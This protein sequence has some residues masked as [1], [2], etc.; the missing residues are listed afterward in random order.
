[1]THIRSV[2]AAL[3]LLA[4]LAVFSTAG[5]G[6]GG[7]GGS[8]AISAIPTAVSTVGAS[9]GSAQ[10]TFKIVVPSALASAMARVHRQYVSPATQGLEIRAYV[11]NN[12]SQGQL[13]AQVAIALTPSSSNCTGSGTSLSCTATIGVPPGDTI[14]VF[15]T[16]G[17]PPTSG[18]FGSATP[19]GA[20]VIAQQII[21][22]QANNVTVDLGG[23]VVSIQASLSVTQVHFV[24]PATS[25]LTL[26]FYDANNNPIVSGP[27]VD[28]NGN[29]I[30]L[31]LSATEDANNSVTVSSG[32]LTP[33]PAEP[34]KYSGLAATNF[35]STITATLSN[36]PTAT[37]ALTVEPIAFTFYAVPTGA[38]PYSITTGSDGA[39][40][41]GTSGGLYRITTAGAMTGPFGGYSVFGGVTTGPDS[42]LW[43]VS[44]VEG[45]S[46]IS[47]ITKTV[48]GGT[49][50]VYSLPSQTNS[51]CDVYLNKCIGYGIATGPDGALWYTQT[52][53][54]AFGRISTSG[55]ISTYTFPGGF[56][57]SGIIAGPAGSGLLYANY[58]I[59]PWYAYGCGIASITTSGTVTQLGSAQYPN[60][61]NLVLGTDGN[62]WFSQGQDNAQYMT[63]MSPSG[64]VL[65][66]YLLPT[67]PI[68][69]VN[70][71]TTN[72]DTAIW[73]TS[74]SDD[75]QEV[76]SDTDDDG[77]N[78][79]ARVASNTQV[80]SVVVPAALGQT[81][82]GWGQGMVSGP[83]NAIWF[84]WLGAD[85]NNDIGRAI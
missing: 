4:A 37:A 41:F 69:L 45:T 17:V 66:Q 64:Q 40:W 55:T 56:S 49:T 27:Y 39:M 5:C 7:G 83:D 18:S 24:P 77:I 21:A 81:C 63:K 2:F 29:P 82:F 73:T 50:T 53:T 59:D 80:W 75:D 1:M 36:G 76:C 6:G 11:D 72:P 58:C 85:G 34:V 33:G 62:I 16:Y 51:T 25:N 8:Q 19:I 13:I 43:A 26:T 78:V 42:N 32:S 46:S 35:T 38:L 54:T 23:V 52:N 48:P 68:G 67:G 47:A 84:L 79:L 10:A 44:G 9:G 14:F 57:P 31:T 70:A 60:I 3:S 15:T 65:A 74:Y 30:T 61:Y 12:G 28:Q 71:L 20:A 22:N